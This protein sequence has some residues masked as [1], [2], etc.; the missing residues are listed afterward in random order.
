MDRKNEKSIASILVVDD[1]VVTQRVLSTQLRK[2]GYEVIT[3]GSAQEALCYLAQ[4]NFDLAI[5]D[6][7]MPE[8]DGITLLEKLRKERNEPKLPV[9]MLTA[10]ALDEDRIRAHAAGATD[11]LTKPI[12]SWE[13]LD[14]VNRQL[15]LV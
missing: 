11:F 1:Y 12:S 7:A 14:V 2:G 3:A 9:I 13:L 8:M 5:I 10:S 4:R 6:V 15:A